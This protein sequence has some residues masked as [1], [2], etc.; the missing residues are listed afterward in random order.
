MVTLDRKDLIKYPFLKESLKFIVEKTSSLDK[1]LDSY[2][3]HITVRQAIENIETSLNY[4]GKKSISLPEISN[5]P[6]FSVIYIAAYP[7]TRLLL[8]CVNERAMIDKTA[9]YLAKV[10]YTRLADE[11]EEKKAFVR[12]S[13]GLPEIVGEIPVST[14]LELV[15]GM[16]D[17][18]WRLIN[19]VVE[20]GEVPV[21]DEEI[22]ELM[23]EK[24][25]LVIRSNLPAKVPPNISKKLETA[26][27]RLKSLWHEKIIEEYGDVNE[28]AFPPCIQA[29]MDSIVG[30]MPVSHM[31]R[32][33]VTAFLHNIGVENTRIASMYGNV[34]DFDLSKT[35]Y[36]VEHISGRGGTGT[37][38]TSPQCATMKTHSLCVH[39]DKICSGVNHPLQY[40]KLKKKVEKENPPKKFS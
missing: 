4:S 36:Q 33:A 30:H 14:Y 11:D 8:S 34:P 20:W 12:R 39:P 19:R 7:V 16:H 32:F 38:Y 35:M 37:E 17:S 3:G 31:G 28:S 27:S 2:D 1:F 5:D 25:R 10:A 22:D 15:S 24:I 18:K 6:E 26:T 21:D 13:L 40:Y 23:Q 29:I 9:R